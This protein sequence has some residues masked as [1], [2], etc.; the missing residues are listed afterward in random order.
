VLADT[1]GTC[2]VVRKSDRVYAKRGQVILWS[3]D[4]QCAADQTV[5]LQDFVD[6]DPLEAGPREKSVAGHDTRLLPGKIKD[7][8]NTQSY[9]YT[10]YL[11]GVAQHDPEII[12]EY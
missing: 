11:N 4:N 1:G 8:V 7:K 6:G 10:V 2:R 3:I 5:S 9:H 12:I